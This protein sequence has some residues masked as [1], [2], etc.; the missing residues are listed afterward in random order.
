M[1]KLRLT[2]FT[3]EVPKLV[4][5]LLPDT[6]A[7]IAANVR[8]DDGALT[9]IRKPRNAHNFEGS[10][11]DNY[12]TIYKH[13]EDWLGWD[14]FVNAAPGPVA[15]D[16]LYY[17]GDGKPK[18]L[19]SGTEYDLAVPAPTTKLSG[20][21]NGT[22]SGTTQTRL[23]VYTFVT[24]FGEESEPS[25]VSDDIDWQNG[26]TVDLSGFEDPATRN[27]TKQ[28]IYRSQTGI[29]GGT[30]LYF[31]AERAVSTSDY[32]D[33]IDPEDFQEPL[34]SLNWNPP[35]D[36]LEGLVSLPNGMMAGFVGKDIYFCEPWR[37]HAWPEGYILTVD[38]EV[39]GLGSFG[40]TLAIAT[41]GQ[42]YVAQGTAPENMILQ[43]IEESLPC[44]NKKSVQDLGYAVAYGSHEGLVLV[45]S[46]GPRLITQQ[47]MSRQ[48]WQRLNPDTM[49]CGQF[50]G[51]YYASYFYT[52]DDGVEH[53]G[54][55]IIDLTGQEPFL[56]R[57]AVRAQAFHHSITDGALYYLRDGSVYEL[58]AS[59][60]PNTALNWKSK[61]F[62]LPR[63]TN[64]GAILVEAYDVLSDAEIAAI[65]DEADQVKADNQAILDTGFI[66]GTLNGGPVGAYTVNGDKLEVPPSVSQFTTV[67]IYAD[68]DLVASVDS[69]NEMRRLPSGF[70]SRI[71]EVEVAS[72][73]RISQIAMAT[74]AA[75]LMEV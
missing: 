19:V 23:Y 51:S 27:I 52:D 41:K 73:M 64:F 3:G 71:W 72:D 45:T 26:Q 57:L 25:P 2:G 54:T 1:A 48:D 61:E 16:R 12:E 20:T 60:K 43:E 55:I 40:N 68:G 50:E 10:T 62:V 38:Y 24:D 49:V 13:G 53:R 70:L 47:M 8:L 9:P 42:P 33:D 44:I 31:I 18:M 39:M 46:G 6:A 15:Q 36:D 66:G 29:S 67:T 63:P 5:R 22:G 37:P 17:T 4:P 21:V 32:T 30:Q 11:A 59:G 65:E 58:D 35:P 34:P 56:K 69:V 14:G 7:Q 28:R 75:E 74:T